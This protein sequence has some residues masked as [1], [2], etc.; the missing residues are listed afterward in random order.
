M[1]ARRTAILA[2]ALLGVIVVG[3]WLGRVAAEET[4]AVKRQPVSKWVVGLKAPLRNAYE[5][6]NERGQVMGLGEREISFRL[7]RPADSVVVEVLFVSYIGSGGPTNVRW[8]RSL[9]GVERKEECTQTAGIPIWSRMFR[10]VPADSVLNVTWG[11]VWEEKVIAGWEV[12]SWGSSVYGS[13]LVK[14]SILI[15]NGRWT[16]IERY[17]LSCSEWLPDPYEPTEIWG[18]W[19]HDEKGRVV[20]GR[21]RIRVETWAGAEHESTTSSGI[22]LS[23]SNDVVRIGKV[24]ESARLGAEKAFWGWYSIPGGHWEA[25]FE[26]TRRLEERKKT[27]AEQGGE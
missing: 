27:E 14:P 22:G 17:P 7:T 9:E 20:R 15:A 23:G 3:W 24:L 4:K 16:Q 13:G 21:Y 11:Y 2:T 12:A 1:R 5:E 19:R 25:A 18:T 10:S 6:T 26:E 8:Y